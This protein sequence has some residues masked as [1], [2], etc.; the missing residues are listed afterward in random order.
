MPAGTRAM[1]SG[2]LRSTRSRNS[3]WPVF[4]AQNSVSTFVKA[5]AASSGDRFSRLPN[6][7]TSSLSP[8]RQTG[9]DT[10]LV[11][12]KRGAIYAGRLGVIKSGDERSSQPTF[13]SDFR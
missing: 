3:F 2:K 13:D 7:Q 1:N 5:M 9:H 12:G 11:S 4:D 6:S 8:G 10:N